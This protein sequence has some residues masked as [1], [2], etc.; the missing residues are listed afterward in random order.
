MEA[1]R[2]C[3]ACQQWFTVDAGGVCPACAKPK[4]ELPL[5]LNDRRFL[6]SIRIDPE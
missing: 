6:K 5:S 2:W 4:D 3:A 1:V